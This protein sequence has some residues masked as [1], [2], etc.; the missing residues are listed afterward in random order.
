MTEHTMHCIT[1]TGDGHVACYAWLAHQRCRCDAVTSEGTARVR[2]VETSGVRASRGRRRQAAAGSA[3]RSKEGRGAE[4][5]V[6]R[7]AEQ[8][9]AVST[10]AAWLLDDET[11]VAQACDEAEQLVGER[12]VLMNVQ[13]HR[14]D[15]QVAPD[16]PLAASEC[17]QLGALCSA[18]LGQWRESGATDGGG[19]ALGF[20]GL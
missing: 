8:I 13:L 11:L 6:T 3:H 14:E 5:S 10:H 1:R 12:G 9:A 17:S 7:Q 19:Q 20:C 16:S 15:R 18:T 2:D 4:W